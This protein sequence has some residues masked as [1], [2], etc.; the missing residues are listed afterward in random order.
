MASSLKAMDQGLDL[1]A[2]D[3]QEKLLPNMQTRK[4]LYELLKYEDYKMFDKSLYNFSLK[5]KE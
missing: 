2:Q 1:L 3:Q 5:K 4:E